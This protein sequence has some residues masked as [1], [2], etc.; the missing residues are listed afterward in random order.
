METSCS[1]P[2]YAI[3]PILKHSIMMLLRIVIGCQIFEIII[4]YNIIIYYNVYFNMQLNWILK[5]GKIQRFYMNDEWKKNWHI[6]LWM[7]NK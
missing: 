5:Y 3:K 2:Y 4:C 6:T 1:L 7:V